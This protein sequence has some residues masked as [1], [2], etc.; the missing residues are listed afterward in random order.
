MLNDREAIIEFDTRYN[1]AYYAWDPFYPQAERDLRFYLGDQWD[2]QEKRQLFEEGRNTF[3]FNRV[4]PVINF[5][6]GF[7]RQRRASSIVTAVE[8]ED[9][10]VASQ[11]TKVLYHV[12]TNGNGYR[13][14]SDCFSGALKT[15]WNLL[16]IWMDYRNDPENGEIRFSREPYNGFICDPYFTD[17]SLDDCDYIIRRKYLGVDAVTSLLP[18]REKEV[19]ELYKIGWERDDKFTWLPYQR[20]PNGENLMA[21]S[22]MFL[23]KWEQVDAVLDQETGEFRV[24]P[25]DKKTL[26]LYLQAFPQMTKIKKPQRMI[27]K[28]VIV[29]DQTLKK[30]KNPYD[31]NEYPFGLATAIFEPESDQWGLK[32]QSFIRAILD[33]QRETNRRR[34]QMIDI[35]D[36]NINSGWIADEDAVVNPRS[37]FQTS[38]GK[39]IW[40]RADSRPGAVEKIPPAQV[41]PSMFQLQE[42]F[43]KDIKDIAGFNEATFGQ[44]ESANESGI[45]QL[46]K[47]SS[48]IVNMQEL[49]DNL[50]YFQQ[51]VT[52]KV[53]K[54]V[55]SWTPEKIE[56]IINQPVDEK[57]FSPDLSKFD[58][59]VEEAV[60]TTTQRQLYF[61]Q[62]VELAQL[63][64]PITGE[65]LAKNAPITSEPDLMAEMEAMQKQ[66]QE[67]QKQQQELQQRLLQSNENLNQAKAISDIALS[68]ERFTRAVANMGLEDE[69]ASASVEN[70]SEAVLNRMKAIK[71]I[72][73][74]DDN[75]ILRFLD[76]FMRLEEL[77]RQK[78]QQI[79]ADDVTISAQA[80]SGNVQRQGAPPVQEQAAMTEEVQSG[81]I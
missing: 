62:L 68:K 8:K 80:E 14:I 4:R 43:D 61:R 10:V 18:K 46:I 32:V 79:K 39:V 50:R 30:E 76:F 9:M 45:M 1:E 75:R 51:G 47:Q 7:Q 29:N 71:E 44:I 15:G 25:G 20:Q 59:R 81:Q 33:P 58:I 24:W 64:A 77:N 41:P 5:I 73:D 52:R 28:Y 65:M 63:G 70:R 78:E 67:Q 74:M 13:C 69:R 23:Q 42:V 27:E 48:S 49:F 72:E 2:E 54:L 6:T 53:I 36:S 11:L 40:R 60:Q 21:Y 31:L 56:K 3:V 57:F 66:Q 55:Q 12:M 35:M 17:I 19:R 37:L 16:S 34:S 26:D 22:E 38:Q